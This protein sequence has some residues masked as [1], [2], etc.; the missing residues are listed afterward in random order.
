MKYEI[1]LYENLLIKPHKTNKVHLDNQITQSKSLMT[2]NLL[3]DY[4]IINNYIYCCATFFGNKEDRSHSITN[5]LTFDLTKEFNCYFHEELHGA[6][7]ILYKTTNDNYR[8]LI[9]LDKYVLTEE[10]KLLWEKYCID[11]KLIKYVNPTMKDISRLWFATKEFVTG[12]M[13][14]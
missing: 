11:L 3:D 10:Y 2:V 13:Y 5:I 4:E 1:T 12:D 6:R 9:L 14:E 7:Y 8:L